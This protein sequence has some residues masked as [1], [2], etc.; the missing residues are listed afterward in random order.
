MEELV[1]DE[2]TGGGEVHHHEGYGD[3]LHYGELL[4][5]D[6]VYYFEEHDPVDGQGDV[7]HQPELLV[8]LE[9]LHLSEGGVLPVKL[10]DLVQFGYQSIDY[11]DDSPR[12]MKPNDENI[13]DSDEEWEYE[14]DP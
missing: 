14:I 11:E 8:F 2:E 5:V 3:E 4:V 1:G 6:D 12:E 10:Y 13:P 7:Q 9:G